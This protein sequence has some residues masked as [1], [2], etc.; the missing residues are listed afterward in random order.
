[1]SSAVGD[2]SSSQIISE[3]SNHP[4][5]VYQ[6]VRNFLEVNK[7]LQSMMQELQEQNESLVTRNAE[8]NK[9][10]ENIRQ[11]AVDALK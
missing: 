9:M 4:E 8:L 7:N 5:T 11:Q 10:A 2:I 3:G 1:M 6:K